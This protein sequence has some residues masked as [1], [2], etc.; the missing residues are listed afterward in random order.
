MNKPTNPLTAKGIGIFLGIPLLTFGGLLGLAANAIQVLSA[1]NGWTIFGI[2]CVVSLLFFGWRVSNYYSTMLLF[3]NERIS[4]VSEENKRLQQNIRAMLMKVQLGYA[5]QVRPVWIAAMV[6]T[7]KFQAKQ[8]SINAVAINS[9]II[10]I[11]KGKKHGIEMGT[12]FAVSC[13][14]NGKFLGTCEVTSVDQDQSWLFH[15]EHTQLESISPN[16]LSVNCVDPP[17]I[18]AEEKEIAE[19]TLLADGY[20]NAA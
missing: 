13:P 1:E 11:D 7:R 17:D 5:H 10:V 16:Q 6:A 18:K 4:E 8:I 14:A 15:S 9:N 19:F 2:V 20:I 3:L 12:F